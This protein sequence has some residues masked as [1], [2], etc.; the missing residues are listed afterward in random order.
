MLNGTIKI[1][2]FVLVNQISDSCHV[3][4]DNRLTSFVEEVQALPFFMN[5]VSHG[6]LAPFWRMWRGQRWEGGR[7]W[8]HALPPQPALTCIS[9]PV[10]GSDFQPVC[11][12]L[13][14]FRRAGK[15]G[16]EGTD[17]LP[18]RGRRLAW[19]KCRERREEGTWVPVWGAWV[20]TTGSSR[21]EIQETGEH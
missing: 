4:S 1:Y 20:W 19:P 7:A 2:N 6:P 17:V 14:A 15:A 3:L 13:I 12:H 18:R 9:A 10:D 11:F 5:R 8:A 21:I 16:Q